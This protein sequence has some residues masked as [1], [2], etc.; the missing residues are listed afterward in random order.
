MNTRRP[1][2]VLTENIRAISSPAKW[3]NLGVRHV[4]RL[5]QMW[6]NFSSYIYGKMDLVIEQNADK[7]WNLDHI[8]EM[9]DLAWL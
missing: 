8:G 2:A 9:E 1:K 6:P 4:T 7:I 5:F 3:R